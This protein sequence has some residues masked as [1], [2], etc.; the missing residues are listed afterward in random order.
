[1]V[2][3]TQSLT[4]DMIELFAAEIGAEI[5]LVD[6]GEEQEVELQK[7]L[8]VEDARRR[9][10]R[11]GRRSRGPRSSPSW[12][13]STTARPS[14][15]TASATPTWSPA[16][17]AASPSTSAPTRSIKDGRPITFIDTPGHEAFTAMRARGAEATDIVVLV[18][19]A[20]DGVMPQ[21]IE[22]LDHAKAAE[23]PIVVAI[24]KIDRENA[25]PDRVMAQLAEHG[26]VP[27]A[28]GGDTIMVEVSALA[29]PRHRRPAREPARRR[30]ARG[31][32]GPTPTAGPRASCS[33]PTSTSAVAPWPRS[34]CSAAPSRSATRWSPVPRGAG[35]GR[36]STTRASRSRRPARPRRSQV[37]GLSDVA[38]AGDDFVVAPDEKTARQ[39]RR[40]PASTGSASPPSAGTRRRRRRRRQARGHLRADPGR[41]GRHAQPHR[42][43]RRHRLARGAHREPQEARARRGEARR[44][45]AA[46]SAASPRTT[47]S[48]PRR[49]TPRSSASTCAPTAR[50]ASWPSRGASRSAPTRSSTRSSRTSRTPWSACSPPSSKR[51]SPAT[52]R[53]A[54]SSGCPRVGAIAGCYVHNGTITR[55]SKVR[56]LREGTIIWKG[57]IHRCGASRT[58]SARCQP[59]FECGIGLSDFQDLKPGDIIETFEEREIP[60]RSAVDAADPWVAMHVARRLARR[61]HLPSAESLK[62]KR[63]VITPDPRGGAAPLP[64]RRRPRS[65]TRTTW[66]RA[67]LGFVAVSGSAGHAGDVIDEVERFVWSFP[68]VEVID[69]DRTWL[70]DDVSRRT[71]PRAT[72]PAGTPAWRGSTSCSGRSSP[73]RS[74]GSTTTA[75]L[76]SRSPRSTSTPTCATP[77]LRRHARPTR[78]D[79]DVLA[80]RSTSCGRGCRPR[81][82]AGPAQAHA[83]ARR[84]HRR[85]PGRSRSRRSRSSRSCPAA[86]STSDSTAVVAVDKPAG[87]TSHDVV[88]K[89]RGLLGTKKVGHA[90]TLDPDATGVLVLGV[91]RAT[92][93]LRYLGDLPQGLRRRARAR[94]RDHHPRRRRRGDRDPRH[95]RGDPRRRARAP[96][97]ASSGRS[98]R[99][100]RWCRR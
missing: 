20:D 100:R 52:P 29:G 19:A 95:G 87:W 42:Q 25:D 99:C 37:L 70:E 88:A 9:R 16:R 65:A 34:S 97:A 93:L 28:W 15:S 92:R 49:P 38:A 57:A 72:A 66:Q 91:G 45:S 1:M 21:T 59:G 36:S 14:C 32:R 96:P 3:A 35:S 18:V 79:D 44:S 81:S 63:A 41:R 6:P 54:R 64:R 71:Q 80:R 74:S 5:R 46:A 50:P 26:L 75:S 58:T 78:A 11:G 23:V 69:A 27:E 22:A 7:L 77:G 39:G 84:S 33:R 55:G 73:R 68:E 40:A 89:S 94:R 85:D 62:A 47:S 31:P 60:R 51:S 90:G 48:W 61:L 67:E 86:T 43:G 82:A 12:A 10:G 76:W 17:P 30:R 98:C 24:N 53:S 56:F 83:R 4:D 13:T 2:T 8:G